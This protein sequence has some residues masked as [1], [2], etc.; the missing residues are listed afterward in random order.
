ML[1]SFAFASVCGAT[2]KEQFFIFYLLAFKPREGSFSVNFGVSD[3]EASQFFGE[4][5]EESE[6]FVDK[7][8]VITDGG[9]NETI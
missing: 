1:L 3:S 7:I 2:W 4:F 6:A 5:F 8:V 9:Q